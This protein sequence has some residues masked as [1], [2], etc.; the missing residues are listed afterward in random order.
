[1]L[2]LQLVTLPA[3]V[4]FD[5]AYDELGVV[6]TQNVAFLKA[7]R[8]WTNGT[9]S[10]SSMTIAGDMYDKVMDLLAEKKI[11]D[12]FAQD[13]IECATAHEH[14]SYITLLNSIRAFVAI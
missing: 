2:P 10:L 4:C 11:D 6:E 14:H 9:Y 1:M 7:S 3:F 8:E 5:K 13:L 12:A